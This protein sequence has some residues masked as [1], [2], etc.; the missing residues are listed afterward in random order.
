MVRKKQQSDETK[1]PG[2]LV[3]A[4]QLKDQQLSRLY[5]KRVLFT[6]DPDYVISL[7]KIGHVVE[8]QFEA[9]FIDLCQFSPAFILMRYKSEDIYI[10]VAN[11]AEMHL[12]EDAD[13][14][15]D[16]L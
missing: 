1:D 2:P 7:G 12:V 9:K 16:I 11:I 8:V 13:N 15:D 14:N 4:R 10:R 6:L 5:N 3:Q